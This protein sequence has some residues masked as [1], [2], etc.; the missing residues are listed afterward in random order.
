MSCTKTAVLEYMIKLII[1][2]AICLL[3]A[4]QPAYSLENVDIITKEFYFEEPVFEKG[5]DDYDIVMV[6]SLKIYGDAGMPV[7]PYKTIELLLPPNSELIGVDVSTNQEITINGSYLIEPGQ[8]PVPISKKDNVN[9]TLPNETIYKSDNPYPKQIYEII[10]V[11]NV[12]GYKVLLLNIYPVKYYPKSGIISYF[13]EIVINIK[14]TEVFN[15]LPINANENFRGLAKDEKRVT[16][17]VDNPETLKKYSKMPV[18]PLSTATLP[19]SSSSYDYVIITNNALKPTFQG[20]VD[21]KNSIGVNTTI[22]TVEDISGIYTGVDLQEKIRNFIKEAYNSWGIEYVLLGGDTE[23]IPHRGFYVDTGDTTDYDIPSDLYYAALDGT[24]DDDLDGLWGEPGEEDLYTEV[25]VGRAP[26][27]NIVEVNNFITKTIAYENLSRSESYLKNTLLVGEKLDSITWGG[28][29]NDEIKSYFTSPWM[30]STLYDRDYPG[31]NWPTSEIISRINEEQHLINHLGHSDVNYSLKMLSSD[32]YY[33]TNSNYSLIYTQGCYSG[34]FDNRGSSGTYGSDSIS[35]LFV[36]EEHG[37]FAMIA[38]SRY[39]WYSPAS[40]DGPSQY[41]DIE[42]FDAIFNENIRN[43]GMALQDSKEDNAGLVSS[44]YMRWCYYELNL[45]GDP[46]TIIHEPLHEPHDIG[47]THFEAPTSIIINENAVINITVNNFGQNNENNVE[48]QF[49]VDGITEDTQIISTLNSSSSQKLIFNWNTNLKDTYNFTIYAVPVA[50][51]VITSNNYVQTNISVISAQILLVDDDEGAD[52]ETY[53]STA[54]NDYEY[55]YAVWNVLTLGAPATEDLQSYEIVIWLTGDDYSA[56]LTSTDQANL[57]DFLDNGGRLFISGQDIGYDIGNTSFYSDYLHAQYV[58]DNVDLT[59][60]SGIPGDPITEYIDISI[61]GGDGANNQAYPSEINPNDVYA[62]PIFNYNGGGVGAIRVDTGTY[63]VVYL[64]FGFE[65][66]NDGWDRTDLM[67]RIIGWLD[68]QPPS[69]WI[70][71]YG[72]T[73]VPAGNPVTISALV[74]DESSNISLVQARIESPDENVLTTIQLFDDGMHFDGVANDGM[75]GNSWTTDIDEKDYH[76]DIMA[77]DTWNNSAEYENI[78]RFTTVPFTATS[79]ILL[80]DDSTYLS[81][82][83]FY[84]ESLNSNDYSHDLWDSDLRG[85][86]DNNVIN[87]FKMCIWSSPFNGPDSYEQSVLREFLDNGGRLFISGQDI[88]YYIGSTSFYSDYLHAQYVSDSVNLYDLSGIS[89]DLITDGINIT[90]LGGNGANNQAWPSEIDPIAPAETIFT[91]DNTLSKE[92]LIGLQLPLLPVE[93]LNRNINYNTSGISSS[94]TAALRIDTGIYRI[95]YFAFGFEAINSSADRDVVMNR[96]ISRWIDAI[97]PEVS[98][99]V[100]INN[101]NV[102]GIQWINAT[103]TDNIGLQSVTANVSNSTWARIY[104]LTQNGDV[105]YNASWNTT[106]QA[107]GPYTLLINAIDIAG[108]QNN[109]ENV[110]IIIDNT[111][112]NIHVISPTDSTTVTNPIITV[113]G[114]ASDNTAVVDITVNGLPATGTTSWSADITLIEG[115]NTV[116]VV[117]IDSAGNTKTEVITI[118]LSSTQAGSISIGSATAPMN[119]TVSIPVSLAYTENITGFS[120]DLIY[121][122]SVVTVSTVSANENFTGSSITPNI[123]NANGIT[124][125]VLTNLNLI[126]A[127]AETNVIYIVFNITGGFGSYSILDL[128]NVEFSD[129]ELNPYTPAVVVDGLITIGIKGD[130]NNN[131]YVDIGDVAKVAFMVAGKVPEELSVDFN[132]NGYVDI[133]DAAK[134][135]FYLAGKV[136]EL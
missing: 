70:P 17:L 134:I 16:D 114:T 135:A 54:L 1:L 84:E 82:I 69:V 5:I 132:A 103:V 12:R 63:R 85:G 2:T 61:V 91:Y 39:G 106:Q 55:S 122:S 20:L 115:A 41:L 59:N 101:T 25:F 111:P 9:F 93:Y 19:L 90:I 32:I 119:S 65:G 52:Y 38:N 14:T 56:T 44:P 126:S 79:D 37:A 100:P 47:L 62:T 105:W 43:V 67:Y 60:L 23:I 22:M 28:D 128:Q 87:S 125:I 6:P 124:S 30:T 77:N 15:T 46:Q 110:T 40:T 131:G 11:E 109:T 113:S 29:S 49:I 89:S 34:A 75:Y 117:A 31:N 33:L 81:Y 92:S 26:V 4:V 95:V 96:I 118:Y 36:V 102:S 53:Y 8:N 112:P 121:N 10:S 74:Y 108:N 76:V 104:N 7:L 42:F 45:L 50:G 120:F 97:P 130:L 99:I 116:T 3:I 18:G 133:G 35:E 51:E 64:A 80:V 66:V 27:G 71:D 73:Y 94:G 83:N 68:I 98:D 129:V 58:L 13:P 88:G 21:W 107:D 24:W 48:V 136:S 72:A 127:S 78:D 86:I 57:A 123:D